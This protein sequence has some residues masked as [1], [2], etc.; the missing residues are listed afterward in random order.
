MHAQP[1]T[2]I[3]EKGGVRNF[4]KESEVQRQQRPNKLSPRAHCPRVESLF[5]ALVLR[6]DTASPP[7]AIY[8]HPLAVGGNLKAVRAIF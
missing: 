8:I 2:K 5:G 3:V 6:S 4:R 1:G 7:D